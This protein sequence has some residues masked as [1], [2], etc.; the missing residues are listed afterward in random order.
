MRKAGK[1]ALYASGML[2]LVILVGPFLYP[3]PPLE[4]VVPPEQLAG[5]D[6]RFLEIDGV[7]IHYQLYG[8]GEP[9]FILMHGFASSTFTWREVTGPLAEDGT[10]IAF[11]R[12][13]HGLTERPRQWEGTNPYGYTA[14]PG[15]IAG[16]LEALA[17]G[18]KAILV[19]NSM[20]GSVAV[21]TALE[22]PEL[23]QALILVDPAIYV[24]GRMG[25]AWLRP[26]LKT[27]QAQ[28]LGPLFVRGIQEWG[29]EFARNA[30]YDPT[31]MTP[32]IWEGYSQPLKARDWDYGLW[33]LNL[34]SEDLNLD[35]RLSEISV[36][37]LVITGSSDTIV[38]TNQSIRL[39]GKIPGAKLVVIEEAG[40]IPHEEQPLAF[41][42][43]VEAFLTEIPN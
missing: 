39:A 29:L 28:R 22:R 31:K 34:A 26:F 25:P 38:P 30:W 2:L 37:V 11:D 35:R 15:Y 10:V 13:A 23:V 3:V 41:L 40:H 12:P 16:L 27:P 14:Q 1:I 42:Q 9:V 20:G 43:A 4:G 24:G 19:G 32:E 18:R 36:P 33:Q 17:P 6:D 8:E 7:S 5:S 21:Y